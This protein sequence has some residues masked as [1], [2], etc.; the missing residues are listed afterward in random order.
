MLASQACDTP[1]ALVSLL[2]ADRQWFKARVGL[3]ACETPL[4][5]SVCVHALKQRN[6]LVIPDLLHDERTSHSPLVTADPYLRFYA[7]A[8]L[9]NPNGVALGTLCVVDKLPRPEGLSEA[10]ANALKALAGQVVAQLELRR[11]IMERDR[12]LKAYHQAQQQMRADAVRCAAL[13][14]AQQAV[15]MSLGGIKPN[16]SSILR[17]CLAAVP[18]ADGAALITREDKKLTYDAAIG[19]AASQA[20]APKWSAVPFADLCMRTGQPFFSSDIFCDQR[21]DPATVKL[22][23][24]R[25]LIIAP[26]L[27]NG[28]NV[29]CL[30]L[31]ARLPGIFTDDDILTAR[32]FAGVLGGIRME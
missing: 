13:I 32:L 2:D 11:A 15:S 25:S 10:Q 1:I 3:D 14:R 26:I 17:D 18:R 31:C 20:S 4:N 9:E 28:T 6:T 19:S 16:I 29:S 27:R 8:R 30:E 21:A 22:S 24:H 12:A 7:G 23:S 5:Q